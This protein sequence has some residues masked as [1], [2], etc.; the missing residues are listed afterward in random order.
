LACF[1][2][3]LVKKDKDGF[4]YYI[5]RQEMF[6]KSRGYRIGPTEIESE[7][8]KY[9]RIKEVVAFGVPDETEGQKIKVVATLK[10]KNDGSEKEI[11]D[12]SVR[13]MPNY[14][15]PSYIQIID[16]MPLTPHGKVDRPTILKTYGIQ[17]V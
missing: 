3:D 9:D 17:S 7:L 11:I 5:G 14:M 15:V 8:Y 2:G 13:N 10:K 16:M 12:Y 6:I 1:S 4:I